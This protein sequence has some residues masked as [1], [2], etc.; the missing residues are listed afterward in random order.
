M[1]NRIISKGS[2]PEAIFFPAS[3]RG[4]E[5]AAMMA[6]DLQT[7][8]LTDAIDISVNNETRLE[9]T[10]YVYGGKVLSRLFCKTN[11]QIVTVS[12]GYF[13]API[14]E[15]TR[16]GTP[17]HV[18]VTGIE[19]DVFTRVIRYS[20]AESN[21]SLIDSKVIVA[22]GRGISN[23]PSLMPPS[24]I[25]NTNIES[26]RGQQGFKLLAELA[27]VLNGAVGASRAAVDAGYISYSHQVGQTGK[28]V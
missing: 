24:D 6:V 13:A 26:W 28:I 17:V 20:P 18:S 10:R 1:L 22:G 16:T 25:D 5:L 7:G 19:N 11:P 12:K 23:A 27:N 4:R 21:A 8:L 2:T 14:Y 15:P 3:S 9:V